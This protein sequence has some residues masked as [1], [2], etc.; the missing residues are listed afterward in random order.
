[1]DGSLKIY[2]GVSKDV[3]VIKNYPCSMLPEAHG[4]DFNTLSIN[5]IL[6][7]GSIISFALLLVVN[8]D[9]TLG[10]AKIVVIYLLAKRTVFHHQGDVKTGYIDY[11]H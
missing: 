5:N 4:S 3:I 6:I 7:E 2:A 10:I 1:M 11:F 8:P 9:F